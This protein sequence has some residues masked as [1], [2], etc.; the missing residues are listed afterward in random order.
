MATCAVLTQSVY[1]NGPNAAP[2]TNIGSIPNTRHDMT[3]STAPVILKNKNSVRNDYAGICIFCHLPNMAGHT[4][5]APLW[6]NTIKVS[7]ATKVK[8]NSEQPR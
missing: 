1:A 4:M 6:D 7:P 5:A 3:Q 2:D 8:T